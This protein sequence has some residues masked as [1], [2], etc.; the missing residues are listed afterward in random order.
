MVDTLILQHQNQYNYSFNFSYLYP[1]TLVSSTD[2]KLH[3]LQPI[4][5]PILRIKNSIN[6]VNMAKIMPPK[7][8]MKTPPMF[9]IE[10]PPPT[11]SSEH[12][13]KTIMQL[14]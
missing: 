4:A 9:F 11:P 1:C 6:R 12:I 3:F 7:I 2:V 10:I 14:F 5:F 13:W 8:T